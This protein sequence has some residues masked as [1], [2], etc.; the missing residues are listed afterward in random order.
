MTILDLICCISGGGVW[1]DLDMICLNNINLEQDY[2][3]S[4]EIDNDE[5]KSR[6]TTS[7]LKFP[8]ES[9]FGKNLIIQAKNIINNQKLI[10]WG[11]IG[12]WFLA[13]QV[14]KYNLENYSWDYKKTCQIPWPKAKDFIKN[15][16]I[17]DDKQPFLHLF[18]EM[19]NTYNINKNYFYKK[20]IYGQLLKKHNMQDLIKELDY[21]FTFKD[22]YY[23][24]FKVKY[25][26]R[27]P[28]RIF[29]NNI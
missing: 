13:E 7:F 9:E 11:I 20:G 16:A 1:V 28:K 15:N 2:I 8:K 23:F 24:I 21:K 3:F 14:K 19:W 4:Q 26:I 6:I 5:N 17:Y 29:K 22:R 18:S 27:H 25:Y 12:P 10:K